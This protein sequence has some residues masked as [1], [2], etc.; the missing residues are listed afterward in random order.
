LYQAIEG[1]NGGTF[2]HPQV[3]VDLA[4]WISAP[5]AVWMDGWFLQRNWLRRT[6]E[7]FREK[8][9]GEEK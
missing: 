3:A 8:L 7:G 9:R 5:F 4:R 2:V 6:L 1:R